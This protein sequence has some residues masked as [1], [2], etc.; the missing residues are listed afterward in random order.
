MPSLV[1]RSS[2]SVPVVSAG[3]LLIAAVLFGTNR[4]FGWFFIG[5]VVLAALF[6]LTLSCIVGAIVRRGASS[7]VRLAVMLLVAAPFA[8]WAASY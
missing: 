4:S 6:L 8:G 1:K 7:D 5:L 3:Y 2:L